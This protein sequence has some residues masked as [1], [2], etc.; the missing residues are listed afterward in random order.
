[1]TCP[2]EHV[3]TWMIGVQFQKQ[4]DPL[5]NLV[6][7]LFLCTPA[8]NSP[9]AA[10]ER[11]LAD[12]R[13]VYFN[14]YL[15]E[16]QRPSAME[17]AF[18][19]RLKKM[20]DI[21]KPAKKEYVS[22]FKDLHAF[23]S[24]TWPG[25][26]RNGEPVLKDWHP[27]LRKCKAMYPD[28]Y[29]DEVK[30]IRL[31]YTLTEHKCA[32]SQTRYLWTTYEGTTCP[33]NIKVVSDACQHDERVQAY[34]VACQPF[35]LN[36]HPS[37]QHIADSFYQMYMDMAHS[38]HKDV[39]LHLQE[40]YVS[41]T[42]AGQ[43]LVAAKRY[44]EEQT[45]RLQAEHECLQIEL[46][47]KIAQNRHLNM[48]NREYNC[49]LEGLTKQLS[50]TDYTLSQYKQALYERDDIIEQLHQQLQQQRTHTYAPYNTFH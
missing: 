29:A 7:Q 42:P 43:D 10:F 20:N 15:Y 47:E 5:Q 8:P 28:W 17:V 30:E 25:G 13:N 24:C 14:K 9:K 6:F 48:V 16:L 31:Q 39:E 46:K 4:L 18:I 26:H 23:K 33:A 34:T 32:V 49:S 3:A 12:F 27:D 50:D 44:L 22:L 21:K 37:I 36:I 1:M 2:P 11:A 35:V 40:L 38:D 41:R 19:E 45:A